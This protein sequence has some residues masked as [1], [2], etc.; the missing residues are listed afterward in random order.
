MAKKD[1][2]KRATDY[3]R[4]IELLRSR[5]VLITDE[6]KAEEHLSDIGYYRLGF[7]IFPFEKTYPELG[8]KRDH[9][10]KPGTKLEDVV[11]FYYY[12]V[13]LRN[14]LNKYLSRIE[15]AIRTTFIYELS[16]KYKDNPYWYVDPAI[17]DNKFINTFK[18]QFY[19]KIKEKEPI[20]RHHKK[21]YGDY[22]PAWKTMEYMTLGNLESLY[23]NLLS[24]ADKALI[25]RKF[26]ESAIN[27]FKSYLSVIREV[28]NS[29]AHGNVIVGMA[30]VDNVRTGVACP[31]IPMGTQNT[32][33]GALRVI[34]YML[35]IVSANRAQEMMEN[36]YNA[37]RELYSKA[38]TMQT[39]IEQKT[40]IILPE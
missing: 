10:V 35:G 39:L 27:S 21:Y 5:G 3:K 12:N 13:D 32:F 19:K 30:L 4:Q 23:D 20:R 15:V 6:Q 2:L 7:Y 33:H 11:A 29:C 36:I 31:T 14:I 28:R 18:S 22:A 25:S 38:P 34:R 26:G 40:G 9:G 24:T 16:N 8:K 1:Y 17:V 37:T